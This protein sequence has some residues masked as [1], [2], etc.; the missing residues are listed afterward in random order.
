MAVEKKRKR[1]HALR[2]DLRP[3]HRERTGPRPLGRAGFN[4]GAADRQHGRRRGTDA[5]R[6]RPSLPAETPGQAE[7]AWL[8]RLRL[9]A[10]ARPNGDL[11]SRQV[12]GLPV[13]RRACA[14]RCLLRVASQ[15][16][17]RSTSNG[18]EPVPLTRVVTSYRCGAAPESIPAP[19]SGSHRIP[20][21]PSPG[22]VG[23]IDG[24]KIVGVSESVNTKYWAR[25]HDLA[26]A[27]LR[28][29]RNSR[30]SACSHWRAPR[31]PRTI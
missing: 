28:A 3:A 15:L 6:S 1:S 21:K 2:L 5:R 14:C 16:F 22:G 26:P 20:F 27:S 17:P 8:S 9:R 12:F 18:F 31:A 29:R 30:N 7:A 19:P 24:H 11:R 13:V 23:T 25:R 4:A 10:Q